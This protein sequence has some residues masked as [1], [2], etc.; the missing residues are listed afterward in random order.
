M[1]KTKIICTMGPNSNDRELMRKLIQNGMDI[2]RINFSHG[3]YE[4]QKARMDMLKELRDEE[5]K[6]IAILLDTKGPEI[7]T[8][9]LKDG[10]K[11]VL[12]EGDTFVLTTEPI[13]GDASKVS[14]TYEGLVQ[15]VTIGKRI[16][17]DDG[18]I[19]LEVI[20]LSD[21][22][23]IEYVKVK[24]KLSPHKNSLDYIVDFNINGTEQ[25]RAILRKNR[26]VLV[27]GDLIQ[28]DFD[29]QKVAN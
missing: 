18:L 1:K 29:N 14:I 5:K 17:I 28:E 12:C 6:P 20:G 13:V 25:A 26:L 16:L 8:G 21:N 7:R 15:D 9:V 4:E 24:Y 11:V 2:A 19:E 23:L 3:N 10:K 22:Y 27:D